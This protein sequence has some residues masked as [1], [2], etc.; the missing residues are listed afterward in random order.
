M[1]E[2]EKPH[3]EI[4]QSSEDGSYGKFV[5]GPFDRGYGT[6]LGNSLRRVLLS[7]I[8]GMAVSNIKINGVV[9]EFSSIKGVKEDVIEIILNLKRLAIKNNSGVYE[10]SIAHLNAS[11]E[12]EVTAGDIKFGN[13][14]EVVNKDLHIATLSSPKSKLSIE[15]T[16]TSGRGY[17]SAQR[18]KELSE[19][20]GVI[21]T[22]SIY[23]PIERV[24]FFV[25]NTRV[26]NI[27]DYDKLIFEIWTNG[28]LKASEALSDAAKI[29]SEHLESF[30][31]I[32]EIATQEPEVVS[33]PS[34]MSI[35][36]FIKQ[37]IEDM[38]LSVRSYNCLKRAGIN[39]VEDL[40]NKTEEDML[41]VRNLGKKS[42]EEVINKLSEFGLSLKAVEEEEE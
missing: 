10:P 7:S 28:T 32:E 33:D 4:V 35:E 41:K 8:P 11:G 30:M 21:P 24:N 12:C 34:E 42:Y 17:V 40:V 26:G 23:T 38:E 9:H 2:F 27:T 31:F 3:I 25:E 20:I 6:T 15:L 16:I 29:I 39:S 5:A 22:D 13:G 37:P 36:R 18:N 19:Q 1:F 14:L